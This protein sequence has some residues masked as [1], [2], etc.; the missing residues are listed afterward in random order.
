[1]AFIVART[2]NKSIMTTTL[3]MM[4]DIHVKCMMKNQMF[5]F[6]FT[7][8]G[9]DDI[10]KFLK[11]AS[12]YPKLVYLDYG[13]T[14]SV[15]DLFADSSKITI[16]PC[17]LPDIDWELF[18]SKTLDGSTEPAH[19]RGLKFDIVID[20]KGNYVSGNPRIIVFDPK[21]TLKK[22][23]DSDSK[24]TSISFLHSKGLKISVLSEASP[25]CHFT[26]ECK[27]NLLNT[28]GTSISA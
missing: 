28:F 14:C 7:E 17:V 8:N 25:L 9:P 5:S 26:H 4:M 27:G 11:Q 19:Q 20:K 2:K 1:M 21:A 23:R 18:K 10:S 3:H 13:V 12:E 15:D 24:N 22:L 6:A 16:V